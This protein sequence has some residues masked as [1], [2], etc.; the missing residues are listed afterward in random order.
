MDY[1]H[2]TAEDRYTIYEL[3]REDNSPRTIAKKLGRHPSTI[4][5]E[6]ERNRGGKGY[7][8]R[9]AQELAES[10]LQERAEGPRIPATTWLEVEEKLKLQWS[11]ECISQR[12]KR[13]GVEVSRESIYNHIV[14]DR[15]NDG[16]LY[17]N[18][19]HQKRRRRRFPSRP[20][21]VGKI[22]NRVDIE[23]RPAIVE[24]RA[25]IGDW[26]ADTIIGCNH[27]GAVVSIVDRAS[28]YTVLALVSGKTTT[29]V[30]GSM[31]A[32]L[33]PLKRC[34]QTITMD[35]G[36]EFAGH[37]RLVKELKADT[38]FARPYCSWQRGTNEQTNGLVRQ[39][40][41]KGTDFRTLTSKQIKAIQELL[42]YRPRRCLNYRTPHEI[43]LQS[44]KSAGV[45]LAL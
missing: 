13:E 27:K 18:L 38:Y 6:L 17:K 40:I 10:R 19:R 32:A 25:R 14:L 45:R 35:N 15:K 44:A 28:R 33:T 31:I 1:T 37:E 11:P 3:K 41:P 23:E 24:K 12:L 22:P 2:L 39:Y 43:F 30:I 42:N 34:V 8:P 21:R 16:D 20:K 5:R 4:Y 7:R 29:E 36:T 9:Q 26:E